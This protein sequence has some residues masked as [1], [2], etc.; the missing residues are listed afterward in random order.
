MRLAANAYPAEAANWRGLP[1][2]A[3]LPRGEFRDLPKMS[4]IAHNAIGCGSTAGRNATL[5]KA[6]VHIDWS[7]GSIACL[8]LAATPSGAQKDFTDDANVES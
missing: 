5:T 4:V 6:A 2:L 8:R 7:R 1:Y 3:L